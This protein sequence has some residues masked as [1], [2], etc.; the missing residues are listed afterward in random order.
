MKD[1]WDQDAWMRNN[2]DKIMTI[3]DIPGIVRSALPL[4]LTPNNISNGFK[5]Q[6]FSHSIAMYL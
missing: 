4:A 5:K 2:P 6:E 3:Y 1:A